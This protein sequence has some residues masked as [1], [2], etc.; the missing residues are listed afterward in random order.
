MVEKTY[1]YVSLFEREITPVHSGEIL[2]EDA[3]SNKNFSAEPTY[4]E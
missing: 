2:L 4:N 3:V 1:P